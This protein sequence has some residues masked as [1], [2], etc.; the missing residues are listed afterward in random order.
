MK[1]KK[2]HL[3]FLLAA[4]SSAASLRAA[5]TVL[6]WDLM[7]AP[8][9]PVGGAGTWDASTTANWSNGTTDAVW[10]NS[11]TVTATFTGTL[12]GAVAVNA[13]GVSV[14]AFN[15]TNT[16]TA[17]AFGG[18][19][20]T[21]VG[22][23]PT[24]TTT[25]SGNVR[26][27]TVAN[28]SIADSITGS[29]LN[30][31][32]TGV[33]GLSNA[34]ISGALTVGNTSGLIL[35][36]TNTAGSVAVGSNVLT[37]GSNTALPSGTAITASSGFILLANG[38][39]TQANLTYN[40]AGNF[41]I[42]NGAN[43]Q[44]TITNTAASDISVNA[45]ATGATISGNISMA[46]ARL[47][48]RNDQG[49]NPSALFNT[50]TSGT[51]TITVSGNISGANS[52]NVGT[53]ANTT[54][55]TLSGSNTYT[56]VTSVGNGSLTI[57]SIKSVS[58]GASAIG[59]PVT[60]AAGTIGLGSG[61]TSGTLKYVGTGDTTDRVVK[62]GGTT[63]GAILDQSGTGLLKFTSAFT[64]AGAGSKTLTLQGSTAG[65]GE[66]AGAIVDSSGGAT[67]L[68]K[69]GTNTWTLSGASTYTGATTISG[70][71]LKLTAGSLGNTAIAV[72]GGT[73]LA[74][75]PATAT[76]ISAGTTGAGSAGATLNLGGKTLD[77]SDGAVST[78]NLQ[79]QT[80]FGSNALTLTNGAT[81]K[82]N[83]GNSGADRLAVTKAASVAGTINVTLDTSL[84][85]SGIT[86][87]TYNL[88]TAASGLTGGTWQFTGGGTT[89][90]ITVGGVPW[91]LTLNATSS[92]VTLG[93]TTPRTLTYDGN[94]NDGGSAPVD[95]LSP[96]NDGSTVTVQFP[97]SLTKTGYAFSNWNTQA[98]GGG[99][100]YPANGTFSITANTTL[101][102]QWTPATSVVSAPATFPSTISSTY[103][104]HP[105]R[106]ASR[107]LAPA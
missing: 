54:T 103:G 29:T 95:G 11:S 98:A 15:F 88:V 101:Y 46:G 59:A 33:V 7:L 12:G 43:W 44:G 4:A 79:Q 84:V 8:T 36:G 53:T 56:E 71:I 20:M 9:A 94:G 18:G 34:A 76:T 64:A 68:T 93:V 92:A 49:V 35:T 19:T 39:S 81:L 100:S 5:N 10:S 60:V 78:F 1:L 72:T 41:Q 91:T 83:L 97:G 96:Y 42:G 57:N 30:I 25:G 86:S 75:Q 90:T 24:I 45:N 14:N 87:G 82:F 40:G 26:S 32:G 50:T 51:G 104:R 23:T 105:L 70:G 63:G 17:Y 73:T 67:A 102:A 28:A 37:I 13:G 85:T 38:V 27:L 2:S 58:G 47:Y 22:T 6:T 62:F 74:I 48:F 69:A 52:L 3:F 77:M 107:F 80:S 31:G 65:T 16:T 61:T 106:P 66:V 21:L 89:Q 55:V 99:T